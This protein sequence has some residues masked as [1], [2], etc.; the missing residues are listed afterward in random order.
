LIGL[1]L[2]PLACQAPVPELTE[3]T[4]QRVGSEVRESVAGLL[5]AMNRGDGETVVGFYQD[6]AG[7]SYLG[8]TDYT[9]GGQTFNERVALVYDAAQPES[10]DL[11]IVG[12]KVLG[13]TA[14]VVSLQGSTTHQS[15]IFSTQVWVDDGGWQ[16]ALEHESWP[17]CSEP[18]GPHPY[19]SPTESAGLRPGGPGS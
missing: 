15:A 17:G 7:F 10:S 19:T 13:P 6:D 16:I 12:L 3:E 14:A 18:R 1:V 4:E 9:L 5:A 2:I 8:C 11:S